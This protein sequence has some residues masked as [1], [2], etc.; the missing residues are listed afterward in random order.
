MDVPIEYTQTRAYNIKKAGMDS[1]DQAIFTWRQIWV[2]R[3][4]NILVTFAYLS[5]LIAAYV[6]EDL[7]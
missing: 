5:V 1:K 2:N 7:K 3:L 4:V 6:D